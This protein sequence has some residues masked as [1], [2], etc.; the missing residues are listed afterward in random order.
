VKELKSR[1]RSFGSA[2]GGCFSQQQE[3]FQ[4]E[5]FSSLSTL[6]NII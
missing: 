4:V 6:P 1:T 3:A 5:N 2:F